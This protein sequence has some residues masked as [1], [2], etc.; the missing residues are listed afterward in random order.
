MTEQIPILPDDVRRVVSDSAR[1]AVLRDLGVL[2][3][4]PDKDFDQIARMAAR[5]MGVPVSQIALIDEQRQWHRAS[6]G[7]DSPKETPVETSFCAHTIA[8]EEMPHLT[9]LDATQDPRFT[10]NPFV[11]GPPFVRFYC[12]VPI[13]VRGERLGTLSVFDTRPWTEIPDPWLDQLHDLA[14]TAASLFELKDE[15]RMRARTAAALMREEWRHALT[16][17][18]GRVG[19]WLWDIGKDEVTCNDTFCRLYGLHG[20]GPFRS[21]QILSLNHPD[22]AVMVAEALG[23]A[24]ESGDD[25]DIEARLAHSS[26]WIWMRGRVYQRDAAGRAQIMMGVSID[27]TDT[28]TA[29]DQTRLLLRELNHRV[30][31]TLAMIQSVA[32]Q[33]WRGNPDPAVFLEAFSGR[34]RTISEA[35]VL[36]AD[37]DWRGIQLFEII[38]NQLGPDFLVPTERLEVSG[39]DI[40]LEPDAALGLA[41][42]L[43][44]LTTNARRHGALSSPEGHI[45]LHWA[46]EQAPQRGLRLHWQETGASSAGAMGAPGLGTRLIERSLAKVLNSSVHL[47]MT[48]T[49]VRAEI[50]IPLPAE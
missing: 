31:N 8:A 37:R 3:T 20:A 39:P 29:A 26:R 16:L 28:K 43:H 48:G 2:D 38:E 35:H 44:E 10:N 12:G 4:G 30:K 45:D 21:E 32:R 33:T 40:L 27:V 49:G 46:I 34:L 15:S 41:L 7:M 18:V 23:R 1:L 11:L 50:W 14:E 6:F 9:V 42:V 5:A 24:L 47:K 22:D 19:S 13:S 36:L 17:E 25:F